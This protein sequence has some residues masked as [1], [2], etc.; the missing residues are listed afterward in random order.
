MLVFQKGKLRSGYL[1]IFQEFTATET[2]GFIDDSFLLD[3]GIKVTLDTFYK[4]QDNIY[5]LGKIRKFSGG[6]IIT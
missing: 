1:L 3:L 5:T 2:R 6:Y 4:E